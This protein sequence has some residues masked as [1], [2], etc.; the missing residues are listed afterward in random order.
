MDR[1]HIKTSKFNIKTSNNPIKNEENN[2]IDISLKKIYKQLM[3]KC[4][5]PQHHYSFGRCKLKVQ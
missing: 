3:N 5:G 4:K 1:E 2:S